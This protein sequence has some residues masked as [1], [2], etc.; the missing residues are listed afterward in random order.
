MYFKL[1][2]CKII[3]ETFLCHFLFHATFETEVVFG[4]CDPDL[5]SLYENYTT[6]Y[7]NQAVITGTP[8]RCIGGSQYAALCNDNTNDPTSAS[9]LCTMYGYYGQ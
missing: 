3:C 6:S 5:F 9:V 8:F 7:G 1:Y 4:V 2:L